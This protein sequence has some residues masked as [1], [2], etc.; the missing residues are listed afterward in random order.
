MFMLLFIFLVKKL[1]KF[2]C[3]CRNGRYRVTINLL[4]KYLGDFLIATYLDAIQESG[5]GDDYIKEIEVNFIDRSGTSTSVCG[6]K[7]SSSISRLMINSKKHFK[8]SQV[9]VLI[10]H[11]A[12]RSS[13]EDSGSLL[14]RSPC[15]YEPTQQCGMLFKDTLIFSFCRVN[16]SMV[17]VRLL[18][19][20]KCEELWT[21]E[22]PGRV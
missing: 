15:E 12:E 13:C 18:C 3:N 5:Y 1:F 11:D 2:T 16:Y 7:F 8:I 4:R 21:Q 9:N 17:C 20:G 10:I 6:A 14:E 22:S 19:L